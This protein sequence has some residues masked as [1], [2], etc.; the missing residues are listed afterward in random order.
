MQSADRQL[1]CLDL[2]GRSHALFDREVYGLSLISSTLH[3]TDCWPPSKNQGLVAATDEG[4]NKVIYPM[5]VILGTSSPFALRHVF[6]LF[7][8]AFGILS[9]ALR[10]G[11]AAIYLVL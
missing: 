10:K 11:N 8:L 9:R 4:E 3:Q 7:Q 1:Y 5:T 6:L 2:K